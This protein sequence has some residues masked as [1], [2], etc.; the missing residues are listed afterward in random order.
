[1]STTNRDPHP[2][3][4]RRYLGKRG[5][6][7]LRNKE[8]YSLCYLLGSRLRGGEEARGVDW[9]GADI[10]AAFF[11]KR[12]INVRCGGGP[13]SPGVYNHPP[14]LG[15]ASSSPFEKMGV[16]SKLLLISPRSGFHDFP[17]KSNK[18]VCQSH[19][20]I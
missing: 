19:H 20:L 5:L 14:L 11:S 6:R 18:P 13:S 16:S 9:S 12:G 1:M 2:R 8:R 7:P 15:L 3:R 4:L 10:P 17:Y